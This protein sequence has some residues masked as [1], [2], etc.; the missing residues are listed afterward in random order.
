MV[1]ARLCDLV[2][3]LDK[4]SMIKFE[5]CSYNVPCEFVGTVKQFCASNL[6][7]IFATD[8]ICE[9]RVVGDCNKG[10]LAIVKLAPPI[11]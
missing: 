8:Y 11:D 3:V 2:N 6:Y 5:L 7:R 9:F 1:K 4:F 10:C